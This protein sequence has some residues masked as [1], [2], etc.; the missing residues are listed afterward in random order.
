[1]KKTI[2]FFVFLMSVFIVYAQGIQQLEAKPSFKGITIGMPISEISNKL[3]FENS[4]NGY[5]IYKVTDT[6]YHS[7]FNVTM[8][9]VRVIGLNGKVHAIEAMKLVKATNE[10]ATV[11]DA[12]ELD[13]IQAGLTRLYGK[14]QYGLNENNAKYNRVG[15]QWISKSK[16]ANCFI[17]FYG[18]FVGYKLQFSLC[19]H[20]ED[21]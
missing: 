7:V 14:P 16:E 21:F 19:E 18:T 5:S 6:Y 3:S 13:I 4:S 10:K 15:A 9:Y 20:S 8:N 1:M 11:F 17:D 2:L 12:T